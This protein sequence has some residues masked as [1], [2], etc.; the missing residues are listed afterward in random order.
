MAHTTRELLC[1]VEMVNTLFLPDF[2]EER[3]LPVR[4][5]SYTKTTGPSIF[6][7]RK[8]AREHEIDDPPCSSSVVAVINPLFC[9][10]LLDMLL[11]E[12]IG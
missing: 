3:E 7:F 4:S 11:R 2:F 12:T 8:V 1:Y 10:S 5:Y 6:N 9:I